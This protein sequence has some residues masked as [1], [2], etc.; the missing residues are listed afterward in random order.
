MAQIVCNFILYQTPSN[1]VL[2]ERKEFYDLWRRSDEQ[3]TKWF[4]RIQSQI[5]RCEFPPII[6]AEYLVMDKFVCE[7]NDNE[8][9]FIRSV[10]TWTLKE[11]NEH[12]GDREVCAGNGG[13]K[14]DQ[15]TQPSIAV[16][17]EYVSNSKA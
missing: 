13:E 9:E 2:R 10:N 4:H 1:K 15:N 14:C 8:R 11:L 6:N 5:G 3:S 7:L 17:C 16:T 12:F